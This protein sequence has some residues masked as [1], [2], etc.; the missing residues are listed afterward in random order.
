MNGGKY[1]RSQE[2]GK[3]PDDS[4]GNSYYTIVNE[5]TMTI[6]DK[7]IVLLNGSFSSMIRNGRRD[8]IG[9]ACN[10]TI[11]GG[12]FSGGL[13]TIKNDEDGV[14][15]INNG[16]FSNY[17]QFSL[18][19]W[20]VATING[21]TFNCNKQA[22]VCV[23][24]YSEYAVGNLTINGGIFNAIGGYGIDEFSSE[25]PLGTVKK[26]S[27]V[28]INPALGYQWNADGILEKINN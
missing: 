15:V 17:V 10:L 16:D 20:N 19:N 27:T 7:V 13:N 2:A 28:S 3:T 21:G 22:V 4:G 25:Y 1:L 5:G 14:L 6:N 8:G 11:N 26:A 23:G 12:A 24:S 18:L 9:V